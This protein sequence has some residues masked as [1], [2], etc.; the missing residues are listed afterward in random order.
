[1]TSADKIIYNIYPGV[2]NTRFLM[3]II[4]FYMINDIN[5]FVSR[6]LLRDGWVR[7]HLK[8]IER[9]DGSFNIES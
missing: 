8:G 3:T 5:L 6:N 7:D 4:Q 9:Q 1:M 2:G